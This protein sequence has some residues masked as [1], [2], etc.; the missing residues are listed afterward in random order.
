MRA[1]NVAAG[2]IRC[3]ASDAKNRGLRRDFARL[4]ALPDHQ[5]LISNFEPREFAFTGRTEAAHRQKGPFLPRFALQRARC[6]G[7]A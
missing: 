5:R 4:A 3:L 2:T 6:I 1:S 7:R